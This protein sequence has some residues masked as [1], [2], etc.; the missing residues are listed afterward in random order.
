MMAKRDEWLS[1]QIGFDAFHFEP[2][3]P[4]EDQIQEIEDSVT[5]F[6]DVKIDAQ[7]T[8]HSVEF[9]KFGF[10]LVDTNVQLTL[11]NRTSND[12]R[13]SVPGFS[14]FAT[15]D[16]EQ[17]VRAIAASPFIYD[18]FHTDPRFSSETA[19]SIKA[20]W[21]G[22]Y[23][24][25]ARG[26]WMVV[27]E[28]A[29]EVTGFLQLLSSPDKNLVIDLIAVAASHQ[30]K[31][32][33]R[34]MIAYAGNNCLPGNDMLVGTQLANVASLAFYQKLGFEIRSSAHMLHYHN[35]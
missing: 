15:L 25:G 2:T 32:I 5:W 3:V 30:G 28:F 13:L 8:E 10:A 16:D 11:S 22:N 20:N 34:D 23:F 12:S 14:R 24:S 35:A 31:G 33:A 1:G 4:P 6:G 18:R 17:S 19:N 9:G 27:A 7:R 26:D 29:G 21:A